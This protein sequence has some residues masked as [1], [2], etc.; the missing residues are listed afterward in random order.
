LGNLNTTFGRL[1]RAVLKVDRPDFVASSRWEVAPDASRLWVDYWAF[2][3]C[4]EHLPGEGADPSL[5]A[6][7]VALYRGHLLEGQC[8]SEW[9][10][11]ERERIHLL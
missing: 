1:R 7:A 8:D 11:P 10:L 9:L 3:T 2:E 4:L 5:A 6:Q